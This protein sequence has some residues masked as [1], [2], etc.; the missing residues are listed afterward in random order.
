MPQRRRLSFLLLLLAV[1]LTANCGGTAAVPAPTDAPQRTNTPAAPT[2]AEEPTTVPQATD[3]PADTPAT[4]DEPALLRLATTTSTADSGLL[5]EILPDFEAEYNARVEVVAVGTGQAIELGEN[6]DADVILV[7][8]RARE[9]A[10]VEEGYGLE[11]QDVMYNDFIIV[12]PEDDAAGIAELTKAADAFDAIASAAAPFASRGDDSGTHT[13]EQAI[14]R[15][16]GM[17]PTAEMEW[18]KSL[19]QGM[20]ETLITANELQAYTLTDRGTYLSMRDRLPNL[21]ILV[22][23]ET[24]E[25]NTD[26]TLFNPYGVIAVNPERHPGVNVELA[27]EFIAWLTSDETQAKIEEFGIE[28]YGQPLF[29]PGLPTTNAA[30]AGA[31]QPGEPAL[32]RLATTTSTADTGLLD[33]ILPAFEEQYN[34]NVEY[35]AVGTGQALKLGET[36]DA[37]IVLVHAR[38]REDA[39]IAQGHGI[40]RRDVMYND[41]VL[42]GPAD[43]PAAVSGLE[44]AAAA[45]QSI[46]DT[47]ALFTSRGDDSG[48]HIKELSIWA[49]IGFTPTTDMA[50]YQSVGQGMGETLTFAEEQQSYVLADRATYLSRRDNLDLE[51]MV[52]GETIEDNTD[53]VLLN[54]YGIIPV[55]PATHP[56]AN[57][58][59]A[60]QFAE[61]FTSVETLEQIRDFGIE[62]FGQPLFYPD[63]EQWRASEEG[64][65]ARPVEDSTAETSE[66]TEEAGEEVEELTPTP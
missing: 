42:L 36:G 51:I 14:W 47:E 44:T 53:E 60:E 35:V 38:A 50:W 31:Q 64:G 10:F 37:D 2:M 19:G 30:P 1:L 32:L 20:G 43:D 65:E 54:Y 45:F 66:E 39:F 3:V 13:K 49:S 26:T 22:G 6:G 46:A 63:S 9:D 62:R 58:E 34:A 4:A 28:T 15:T 17:T 33:V 16:V 55:N 18:Y 5:D 41:F 21:T 57:Y 8:A 48:T 24:I 56:D 59:L 11:R 27:E 29:F 12:G 23:G 25:D 61:W 40:D 52:G 7:H